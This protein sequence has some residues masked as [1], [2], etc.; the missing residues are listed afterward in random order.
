MSSPLVSRP[1]ASRRG[2]LLLA[3]LLPILATAW[4]GV[5]SC[6]LLPKACCPAG[7]AGQDHDGTRLKAPLPPCCERLVPDGGAPW[8]AKATQ[9]QSDSKVAVLSDPPAA[10]VAPGVVTLIVAAPAGAPTDAPPRPGAAR[11]PPLA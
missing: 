4:S 3:A 5:G 2:A 6:C 8:T 9:A 7:A 10:V 1:G 11:A